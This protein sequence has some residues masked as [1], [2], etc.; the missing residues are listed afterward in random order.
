MQIDEI[1]GIIVFHEDS[2]DINDFQTKCLEITTY[3]KTPMK[4]YVYMIKVSNSESSDVYK[5]QRL[6]FIKLLTKAPPGLLT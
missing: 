2:L 6:H 3:A 4:K 1:R 5:M